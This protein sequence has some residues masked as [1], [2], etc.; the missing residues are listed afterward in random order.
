MPYVP[1]KDRD[2]LDTVAKTVA[3]ELARLT[4]HHG[5]IAAWAGELNY[6][7]TRLLQHLPRS[8]IEVAG[9]KE[10]LRYWQ[11]PLFFG[12]LLDVILEYKRR[13]NVAYE[14]VQINKNGDC[15]DTPYMTHLIPVHDLNTGE[16]VGYMEIM[17]TQHDGKKLEGRMMV[18]DA[19]SLPS[20]QKQ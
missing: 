20:P 15:F 2:G 9:F 5:Y 10:E 16:K 14:S 7:L 6:F 11:Q 13:V 18:I 12:V 17:G 8:L 19:T 3:D 4:N 1:T